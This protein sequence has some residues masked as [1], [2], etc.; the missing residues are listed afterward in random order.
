MLAL[1]TV[2]VSPLQITDMTPIEST[3]L[4][5]LQQ[6]I[7]ANQSVPISLSTQIYLKT[8]ADLSNC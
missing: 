8:E 1:V 3:S 5:I 7:T 4:A 2:L 6:N